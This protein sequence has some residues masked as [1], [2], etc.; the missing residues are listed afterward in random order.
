MCHSN[1]KYQI[2]Y[3]DTVTSTNDLAREEL[4]HGRVI[5][6]DFQTAGRGQRGNIWQAEKASSIL[7]TVVFEMS[8]GENLTSEK[9]S[10]GTAQAIV[11][12]LK[13]IGLEPTIKKPND[14]LI[15]GKKICG[16]LIEVVNGFAIIGFGINIS[17]YP[18]SLPA[19]S[20]ENELNENVESI[21][22]D[23]ILKNILDN[24]FN[25]LI[26]CWLTI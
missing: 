2:E 3:Y 16:I 10:L 15:N 17:G 12:E 22:K 4:F 18:E 7:A 25:N 23:K 14:I 6:A 19:T 24:F 1:E 5:V 21:D 11:E 13:N 20:V 8:K 9:L 26:K